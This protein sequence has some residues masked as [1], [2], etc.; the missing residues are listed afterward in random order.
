ML[1]KPVNNEWL[2]WTD[3]QP[4]F[5]VPRNIPYHK[6]LIPTNDS[7]RNDHLLNFYI[8]HKIHM[9]MSGQTGTGKTVNIV[10]Q[11][12][13]NYFNST[14]TNLQTAFSGQTT[15][16][17]CQRA[18]EAKVCVRRRK[19]YYGPEEGK[20]QIVIFIDDMNMPAKEKYGAQPP[21][22]LLR[23][24]MDYGGWYDLETKEFK[25]L[26]DIIFIAAMLPPGGGRNT[27]SMRYMRHFSLLYV[28]PFDNGSLKRI[29]SNV[30]DWFLGSCN[31]PLSKTV[32]KMN[33]NIV[34]STI[35]IYEQ[36]QSVK[37]LLPTPAKAHYIYNLR[38]ISK[39]FLG[40]SRGCS[41]SLINQHSFIK[42]WAHE[43]M[44]IFSDRMITIQ[45][46]QVFEKLLHKVI[47][48]EY[49]SF[50]MKQ[51][52]IWTSFLPCIHPDTQRQVNYIYNEVIDNDQLKRVCQTY[53]DEHNIQYLQNRMTLVFFFNA[54]QHIARIV[55]II[56][57]TFG[58]AMLIGMGGT[59]RSSL[60]R[61][62]S[63]I[64]I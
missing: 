14:F 38:D 30:L 22:E 34:R 32:S 63:F 42:L 23:Q 51:D 37:E 56:Q 49:G 6:L 1:Y 43:C 11:L 35:W 41:I 53:L 4:V 29:F 50:T 2:Q 18:I 62:S 31:P 52:S 59:G 54:I 3:S 58:H 24:W 55:R 28:P 40:L 7:I 5:E 57:T 64:A 48:S 33:E 12:N 20:A 39:I 25:Y 17:Q 45:D 36:V 9:L 16:N 15:A 61:L 44:R 47:N 10:S 21:I 60:A 26:Q 13:Q 46:Q 8:E 19:G 27:P